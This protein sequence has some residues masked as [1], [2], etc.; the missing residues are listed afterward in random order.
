MVR[1]ALITCISAIASAQPP[2]GLSFV[3]TE[4]GIIGV[5]PSL[6]TDPQT[7]ALA[8]RFAASSRMRDI[9]DGRTFFSRIVLDKSDRVYLGYELLIER[10]P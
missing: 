7:S 6:R 1:L 2:T 9:K 3:N 8:S 4:V 5:K 10:V